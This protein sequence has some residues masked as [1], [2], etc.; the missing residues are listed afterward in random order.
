MKTK[1]EISVILIVI[2][3]ALVS[4]FVFTNAP[5]KARADAP[6]QSP[7]YTVT[8]SFTDTHGNAIGNKKLYKT[9][10]NGKYGLSIVTITGYT[11]KSSTL[12]LAG[13]I[14]KDTELTMIYEPVKLQVKVIYVDEEGIAIKGAPNKTYTLTLYDYLQLDLRDVKIEG[15][16]YAGDKEI[17]PVTT[18]GDITVKLTYVKETQEGCAASVGGASV[19]FFAALSGLIV[20][21]IIIRN[22]R[23]K[24]CSGDL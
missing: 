6:A 7:P 20:T 21:G 14:E 1:T 10:S 19:A 2:A 4:I 13:R 17:I 8:V 5:M 16:R 3:M 23:S 18:V 24:K 22:W 12:P 11:F 15:Y 9:D